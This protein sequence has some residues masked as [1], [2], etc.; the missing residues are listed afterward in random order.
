MASNNKF[1]DLLPCVLTTVL[2]APHFRYHCLE[3]ENIREMA[4]K[5]SFSRAALASMAFVAVLVA[6]YLVVARPAAVKPPFGLADDVDYAG[7]LWRAM[8]TARLVGPAFCVV[9]YSC[10]V[11]IGQRI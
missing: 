3:F 7:T 11:L 4:M 1:I 9:P 8:V 10:A 5:R 2:S 6:V